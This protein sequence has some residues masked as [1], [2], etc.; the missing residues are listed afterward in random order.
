MI[1]PIH[2]AADG[3][4]IVLGAVALIEESRWGTLRALRVLQW[5]GI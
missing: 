5:H 3:L 2:I 1:L 4:A